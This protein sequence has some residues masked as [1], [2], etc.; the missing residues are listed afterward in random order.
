MLYPHVC[1]PADKMGNRLEAETSSTIV[2][3]DDMR[4]ETLHLETTSSTVQRHAMLYLEDV[5]FVFDEK[6]FKLPKLY[7]QE[8][9]TFQQLFAGIQKT[10]FT[11][12]GTSGKPYSCQGVKQEQFASLL[13]VLTTTTKNYVDKVT[14]QEWKDV[15][16]LASRWRMEKTVNI[17]VHH[18]SSMELDPIMKLEFAKKH[19]IQDKEWRFSA[20]HKLVK[21]DTRLT[22]KAGRSYWTTMLR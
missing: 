13:R 20:I 2:M 11:G 6:M 16:E 1:T 3:G 22:E 9:P 5:H 12:N 8:S 14:T 10:E 19:N 15:F 17:A 21:D 18:L 4:L 7:L